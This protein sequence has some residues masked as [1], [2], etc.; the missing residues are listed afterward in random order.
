MPRARNGKHC[1]GNVQ[2]IPRVVNLAKSDYLYDEMP[3]KAM[4][5]Y[6]GYTGGLVCEPCKYDCSKCP[7]GDTLADQA[8]ECSAWVPED[9]EKGLE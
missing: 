7:F 5:R 1:I 4:E 2:A 8:M 3:D 6:L 9:K